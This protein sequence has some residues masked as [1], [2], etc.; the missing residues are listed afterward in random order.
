MSA[1]VFL[2]NA[3]AVVHKA[4]PIFSPVFSSALVESVVA[5]STTGYAYAVT[6]AV[7]V[8]VRDLRVSTLLY[9]TLRERQA[10]CIAALNPQPSR[11]ENC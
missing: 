5:M 4:S 11:V 8:T 1:C 9:E 3:Q 6:T 2:T 10:Q 7:S